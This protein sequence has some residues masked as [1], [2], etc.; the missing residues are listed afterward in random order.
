MQQDNNKQNEQKQDGQK[1]QASN[2]PAFG[3]AI[4]MLLG[5]AVGCW[6]DNLA[7]WLCIGTSIGLCLGP[8][9]DKKQ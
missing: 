8:L 3:A 6:T 4:G 7:L 1:K 9:F 5:V 2:G